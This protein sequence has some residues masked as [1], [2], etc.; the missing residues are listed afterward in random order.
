MNNLYQ[1]LIFL[2]GLEGSSQGVKATMLRSLFPG[3]LTPDFSGL[4]EERMRKLNG[5]LGAETGW[6][7]IGSSFGGL[8]AAIFAHQHPDQVNKL[9]LLAPAITLPDFKGTPQ[10]PVRV[11]TT[12]VHG[13]RD[14]LLPIEGVRKIAEKIFLN[15]SFV[16]VDD[17]HG[18][19]Q[20]AQNLDWFALLAKQS[21]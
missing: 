5:I 20:T 19:Y 4:L 2:H 17:D 12:I 13:T 10:Q 3:I 14:E 15:L 9:I 18:L 8:M 7:L 11:P 6:T 21:K 16:T 1:R